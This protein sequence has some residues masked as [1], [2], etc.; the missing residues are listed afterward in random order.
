MNTSKI[1]D[2]FSSQIPQSRRKDFDM[3]IR[4]INL[5]RAKATTAFFLMAH[6]ILLPCFFIIKQSTRFDFPN[7]LYLDLYLVIIGMMILYLIIFYKFKTI[8]ENKRNHMICMISFTAF[9]Q[10]WCAAYS[11]VDQYVSGEVIVYIISTLCIAIFPL[12]RTRVLIGIF[13]IV[14]IVFLC[15]LQEVQI[16]PEKLYDNARNSTIVIIVALVISHSLWKNKVEDYMKELMIEEKNK[17]LN[18]LNQRLRKA[19]KQLEKLSGTDSL[20]GLYNRRK[21]DETM[22]E[23]WEYSRQNQLPISII[24][25]DIDSFKQVNDSYGHLA[26]DHCIVAIAES[27]SDV[28]RDTHDF[29]ARLGGDE[30][31]LVLTQT[32]AHQAYQT[33]EKLRTRIETLRILITEAELEYIT[34]S[35]GICC[36]IPGNDSS[37]AELITTADHALYQAKSKRKNTTV[38]YQ[39]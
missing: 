39:L 25:L 26:G 16:S 29:A 38:A 10:L 33:G 6:L 30:F 7:V 14:H 8:L 21:F 5:D 20:T 12:F 34:V 23:A 19:N 36:T 3:E 22:T 15:L 27:I 17:D 2:W 28:L 37:L 1:K 32:D 11:L 9:L 24:M 18:D 13:L 35:L 4:R 31:I